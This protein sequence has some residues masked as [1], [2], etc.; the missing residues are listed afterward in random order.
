MKTEA[1]NGYLKNSTVAE[2][3]ELLPT[4]NYDSSATA[5]P[6]QVRLIFLNIIFFVFF[7]QN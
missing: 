6:V 4:T 3:C 1:N 5:T 2:Q 7:F